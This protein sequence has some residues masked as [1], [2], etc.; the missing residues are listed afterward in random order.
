MR[1]A[2]IY[3]RITVKA[4]TEKA[5]ACAPAFSVWKGAFRKMPFVRPWKDAARGSTEACPPRLPAT[6]GSLPAFCLAGRSSR[7]IPRNL[8]QKPVERRTRCAPACREDG[9]Y[10]T[11]SS[12]KKDAIR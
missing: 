1:I 4:Q 8:R 11:E 12:G 9:F 10:S 7:Y 3:Y 5:G 2:L 6:G